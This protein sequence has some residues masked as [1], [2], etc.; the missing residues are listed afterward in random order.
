MAKSVDSHGTPIAWPATRMEAYL[1]WD[2]FN[3]RVWELTMSDFPN[4]VH[5]QSARQGLYNVA[6]KKGLRIRTTMIG[7]SLYFQVKT[8]L[9]PKDADDQ[10]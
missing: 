1:D 4:H 9:E 3:G 5:L 6:K 8:Q 10:S 2:W 7:D